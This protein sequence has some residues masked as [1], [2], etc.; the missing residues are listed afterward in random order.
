MFTYTSGIRAPALIAVL[1]DTLIYVTV[2]AALVVVPWRLG[3]YGAVF[4]AVP[5]AKL[6]LAPAGPATLGGLSGYVSLAIGSALALF[7]YPHSVTGV[8]SASSEGSIRRNASLLPAYTLLLAGLAI[9]GAMALAA[10]V[11]RDPAF[12]DLFRGYGPSAAVPAL[13]LTMFPDWFSGIAFAAIGIGALVPA[14]IMSI[15]A[16][17]LF[18]RNIWRIR[19]DTPDAPAREA[20][21]AKL[22]SLL[23]K[24]GALAFIVLVPARYAIQLQLLGGIWI[25]QTFPAVVCGLF[26]PW[27]RPRATLLGLLVGI[28]TGT[29]L[30]ATLAF[31]AAI[32][33]VP[34]GGVAVPLYIAIIALAL[35]AA[36]AFGM[37]AVQA[38]ARPSAR[39][40][41]S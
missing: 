2:F 31:K 3:G 5:P 20:R 37:S 14:A 23:V 40:A 41:R 9:M 39:M 27:L 4:D 35:N 30:V 17:N 24:V 34:I 36:V 1:K 19:P 33:V 15:A 21:L 25:T 13:F 22:V 6:L 8:L 18:V 26:V 7:L 10:G 29:W 12:A 38:A 11:D 32:I 28:V 16:A